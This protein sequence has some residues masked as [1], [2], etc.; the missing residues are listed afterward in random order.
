VS[1]RA[2][3]ICPIC[4]TPRPR[5]AFRYDS[6]PQGE[7]AFP[8]RE[9]ERYEREYRRCET[10]GHLV[11]VHDLDVERLY[12]G[13]YMD[14]TYAGDRLRETFERIMSLPPERSDNHQRVGRI[15]RFW[16]ERQGDGSRTLLD[17]GSGL[18][19]FS[20]RMQ[21]AGWACTALDPDPR[22]V[23]H[24]ADVVGVE[25]VQA[26]FDTAEGLGHFDLVTFNKV[27]EHVMDPVSMLGRAQPF[28]AEDGVVYVEVPDGEAAAMEGPGREEFFVE[29][30]H[31]FSAASL[32]LLAARAG[33][34][35]LALERI[36]EP[37]TKYTLI[38]FVN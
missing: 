4:G 12:E 19:V 16:S 37:S 11:A 13:E 34:S 36:R 26:D 35:L 31:V 14:S 27:L 30:L 17:V 38:A 33:F 24:A 29:H 21:E 5:M 7:T 10:C 3:A 32:A 8:L 28:L 15:E 2:G 25:A 22:S 9:G 1:G 6:P 18:G 23:Q 20:A